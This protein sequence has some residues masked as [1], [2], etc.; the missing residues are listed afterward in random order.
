M[1]P[2]AKRNRRILVAG[3]TAL[4]LSGCVS[5]EPELA[6]DSVAADV[7]MRTGTQI[8]WSPYTEEGSAISASVRGYLARELTPRSA[9]QIALLN[10]RDLQS[11]YTDIGIAQAAVVQAATFKNPVVDG[12][13]TWFNDGAGA[14]N[15]A[16]G[17]AWGFIDLLYVPLRTS[18]AESELEEA[19]LRVAGA[20]VEHA[21]NT[22]TAFFDLVAAQQEVT[23]FTRV[24]RSTEAVVTAAKSL[25]RAG[26]ITE[27]QFEQQQSLLTRSKLQLA[28]ALAQVA[29][30][31]EQLNVLMGV[32]GNDIE[33]RAP[34]ALQELPANE[35][36]TDGVEPRAVQASLD[37][38]ERRQRLTTIGRRFTLIRR[39]SLVPELDLG[40]EYE[41]EIEVEEGEKNV[42]EAVSPTFG[43]EIPI[44][45]RGK[46]EK[47]DARLKLIKAEHDLWSTA[48]KVRS[49]ARL[50]RAR[51]LVTRKT[52]V[53]YRDAIV[54]EM[55]RL[56]RGTQRDFNAMQEDV[57]RLLN[58]KRTQI[59]TGQEYI[60]ALQAYWGARSRF[61]QLMYGKLPGGGGAMQVAAA[62]G[63]GGGDEEH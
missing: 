14:P 18:V 28:Q 15:I 9:V 56:L 4:A 6:F 52:A 36:S 16:F 37:I 59:L 47:A 13:I 41:R 19:K 32:T 42:S 49:A 21:A 61:Q 34:M 63:G 7:S 3:A 22:Q 17:V 31:R 48:V 2:L 35:V 8:S 57:F 33:W 30:R 51:L 26:N 45:D 5:L 20:V 39:S 60:R 43:F 1:T 40:V 29:E 23:L 54:P 38:E 10:N 24:V 46:A 58:T 50:A 11:L 53:Y 55:M 44:F 27:L 62:G 25:R 12:A